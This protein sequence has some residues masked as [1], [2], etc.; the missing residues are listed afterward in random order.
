MNYNA[1]A[2]KIHENAVKHGWYARPIS[3][4]EY[5][6]LFHSEIS[7]AFE[8]Y[9]NEM[10]DV[11]WNCDVTGE[12]CTPASECDCEYYGEEWDCT[13]RHQEP[14][15]IAIELID[16]VI[17]LLDY[18]GAKGLDIDN[19]AGDHYSIVPETKE[20]AHMI[21]IL[22]DEANNAAY[23]ELGFF[24]NVVSIRAVINVIEAYCKSKG[25]DF[26]TLLRLK[27]EYNK[28]RP[29]RHGGKRC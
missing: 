21:A 9:R 3:D 14:H 19:G 16:L 29:Y 10:P 26:E 17:R 5:A 23:D 20:F 8:E 22:H 11:Y 27:H 13:H 4:D 1:W 28:T 6:A 24:F 2:K 25:L 7:E 12:I 15:G 18:A